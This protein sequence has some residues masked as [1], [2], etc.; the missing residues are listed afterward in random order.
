MAYRSEEHSAVACLFV[1]LVHNLLSPV[2]VLSE[3]VL[4][5]SLLERS[6][7]AERHTALAVNAVRFI[8]YHSVEVGVVMV[9]LV[10]ALA[11]TDAALYAAVRVADH[12]KQRIHIVNS[13]L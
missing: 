5:L 1:D 6:C 7:R 9:H 4:V 12:L 8:G 2:A 13:H 11:L 10:G 3:L